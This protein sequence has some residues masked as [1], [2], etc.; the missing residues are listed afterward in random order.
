M[1]NVYRA[2][3]GRRG[4]RPCP[5]PPLTQDF[6]EASGG[7][8]LIG[9]NGVEGD[10]GDRERPLTSV[11]QR[12]PFFFS[13]LRPPL[14]LSSHLET[15]HLPPVPLSS[16]KACSAFHH[17]LNVSSSGKSSLT[18]LAHLSCS[19]SLQGTLHL[20]FLTLTPAAVH[21][22]PIVLYGVNSNESSG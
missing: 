2:A 13:I 14:S 6:Q 12:Q 5:C 20:F 3:D 11:L 9:R 10:A 8:G 16:S 21:V 22:N 18:A 4:R 15:P 1:G 17:N 19:H 7:D